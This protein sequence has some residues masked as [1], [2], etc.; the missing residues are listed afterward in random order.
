MVLPPTTRSLI[1]LALNDC[2]T[3][4]LAELTCESVR[5]VMRVPAGTVCAD[6]NTPR[7]SRKTIHFPSLLSISSPYLWMPQPMVRVVRSIV[8][9]SPQGTVTHSCSRQ[10]RW[11]EHSRVEGNDTRCWGEAS[12]SCTRQL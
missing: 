5:T 6:A 7:A 8:R 3:C 12:L 2:P 1:K 9:V 4:A 10:L 11:T